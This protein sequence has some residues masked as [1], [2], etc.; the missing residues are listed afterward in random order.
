MGRM[1]RA[2]L[3]LRQK[4]G[5]SQDPQK[6]HG[7]ARKSANHE[8]RTWNGD[9]SCRFCGAPSRGFVARHGHDL[10]CPVVPCGRHLF[11]N[12]FTQSW[13]SYSKTRARDRPWF[14][15]NIYGMVEASCLIG[16]SSG[17]CFGEE[18]EDANLLSTRRA[19]QGSLV[20]PIDDEPF[21]D[22]L[23][24]FLRWGKDIL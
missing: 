14:E 3:L 12:I 4:C 1:K 10:G 9:V 21:S 17:S 11:N 5:L 19:R 8:G 23:A 15:D 13:C 7:F 18:L 16:H 24:Q 6:K 22:L 2:D 20:D